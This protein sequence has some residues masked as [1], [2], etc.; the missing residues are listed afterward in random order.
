M[1]WIT[2]K[3]SELHLEFRK[4]PFAKFERKRLAWVLISQM[5]YPFDQ[6]HHQRRSYLHLGYWALI[7]TTIKKRRKLFLKKKTA[8]HV[9]E[10]SAF[11][12]EHSAFPKIPQNMKYIT[13]YQ[14]RYNKVLFIYHKLPIFWRRSFW[15]QVW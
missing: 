4:L 14:K 13:N 10:R 3:I 15:H 9:S 7:Y 6:W 8:R 12:P 11:N 1:K 5:K 2:F